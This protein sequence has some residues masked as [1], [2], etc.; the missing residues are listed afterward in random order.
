MKRLVV[1]GGL[2][3]ALTVTLMLVAGLRLAHQASSNAGA[4]VT[5]PPTAAPSSRTPATSAAS[6]ASTVVSTDEPGLYAAAIAIVVFGMDTRAN[7]PENYRGALL[8][9]ADPTL[10]ATGS[11]DLKRLVDARIPADDLWQRMRENEQWSTFVVTQTWEPG[12]WQQ[13]VTAGQAEPGWTMRNVTG[14]QTTHYLDSGEARESSRERT[15]TVGM[16]CPADDAAVD[17]CRLVLLGASTV[18]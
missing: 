2:V 17:R 15:I 16:R 14:I 3:A 13:V 18:P 10:S 1:I 11:D 8:A 7:E 9:E 4:S 5:T 6:P 12:S